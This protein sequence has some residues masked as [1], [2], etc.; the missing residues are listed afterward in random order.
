M[1][2]KSAGAET[3]STTGSCGSH[4]AEP[5]NPVHAGMVSGPDVFSEKPSDK[6]AR[7]VSSGNKSVEAGPVR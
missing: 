5:Q 2:K 4:D 6:L 7:R 3:S 1:G